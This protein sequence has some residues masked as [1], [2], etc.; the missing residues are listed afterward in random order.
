MLS[1]DDVRPHHRLDALRPGVGAVA[2]AVL[3]PLA[4][5]PSPPAV[6]RRRASL[7][8]RRR[9]AGPRS[10]KARAYHVTPLRAT[11]LGE[12]AKATEYRV[13]VTFGEVD[14]N[15]TLPFSTQWSGPNWGEWTPAGPQ[16]EL[17]RGPTTPG[18]VEGRLFRWSHPHPPCAPTTTHDE[19]TIYF[20]VSAGGEKIVGE[21][22]GAGSGTGPPCTKQ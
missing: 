4:V 19:V 10:R 16:Q 8:P 9:R 5:V 17:L 11:F 1:G 14:A 21:Y 12:T 13:D 3:L 15:D 18:F 7:P 6:P 2:R 22:Q 20:T